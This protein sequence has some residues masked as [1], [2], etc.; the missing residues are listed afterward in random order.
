MSERVRRDRDR[1]IM[2]YAAKGS[3]GERE[4]ERELVRERVSE[5]A[6]QTL[7]YLCEVNR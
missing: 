7:V 4:R 2:M 1:I 6:N 3:S 5:G